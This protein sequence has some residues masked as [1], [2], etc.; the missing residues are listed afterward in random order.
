MHS[1]L[2]ARQK[3]HREKWPRKAAQVMAARKQRSRCALPGHAA[4][5]LSVQPRLHLHLLTASQQWHPVTQSP[6]Q[7]S[8]PL[9]HERSGVAADLK[10]PVGCLGCSVEEAR[11]SESG[12]C[13]FHPRPKEP[14][15][16]SFLS[17]Y[18]IPLLWPHITAQVCVGHCVWGLE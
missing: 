2:A 4:S 11:V 9:V 18:P 6:S 14:Y 16:L 5:D 13:R 1:Q 12:T 15:H 10:A 3:Q 17:S 8:G 7:S